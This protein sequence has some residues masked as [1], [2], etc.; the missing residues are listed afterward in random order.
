MGP[1]MRKSMLVALAKDAGDIN[2]AE[3]ARLL[4]SGGE[5]FTEEQK[6]SELEEGEVARR[7]MKAHELG[8]EGDDDESSSEDDY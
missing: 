1:Y 6:L 2:A 7:A 5:T 4:G 8:D 3:E